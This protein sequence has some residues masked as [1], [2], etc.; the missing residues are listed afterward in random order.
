[1]WR[2]GPQRER[3]I[4]ITSSQGCMLSV[5]PISVDVDLDHLAECVLVRFICCE[6]TLSPLMEVT[7]YIPHS[8]SGVL[9]SI[10]MKKEDLP[11]LFGILLYGRFFFSLAFIYLITDL[12]HYGLKDIY[13]I[14]E[15]VIHCYLALWLKM[16]QH[17]PWEDPS[18][19]SW[20]LWH[21]LIIADFFFLL[22]HFLISGTTRWSRFIFY[23]SCPLENISL[24][25]CAAI[26]LISSVPNSLL[27]ILSKELVSTVSPIHWVFNFTDYIFA[28]TSYFS[29]IYLSFCHNDPF[30]WILF[31]P[32]F[33]TLKKNVFQSILLSGDLEIWILGFAAPTYSLSV[34]NWNFSLWAHFREKSSFHEFLMACCGR[35]SKRKFHICLWY[36]PIVSLVLF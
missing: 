33:N 28:L 9:C 22:E 6:V 24:S 12:D 15:V 32:F 1:M 16:F 34:E 18:I 31:L 10:S 21:A 17:W 29:Q 11:K 2:G 20:L 4:L 25:L 35:A 14:F 36:N 23:I 13:F 27:L 30:L 5:W 3:A 19:G 26:W 7:M 8:E